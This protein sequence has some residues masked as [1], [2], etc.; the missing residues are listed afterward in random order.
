MIRVLH[1]LP[2]EKYVD[3]VIDLW[4]KTVALCDY[5]CL[6]KIDKSKAYIFSDRIQPISHE[7]LCIKL[8]SNEYDVIVFSSLPVH[9]YQYVLSIPKGKVVIWQSVGYDIYADNYPY[10]A[11]VSLPVYKQI[12]KALIESYQKKSIWMKVRHIIAQT[13]KI[14]ATIKKNKERRSREQ[15]AQE[16]QNE[17]LSRIDYISTVLDSE[18][19]LLRTNP[20]IKAK[21]FRFKYTRPFH[22]SYNDYLIDFHLS[23]YILIGNS[24]DETNNH[25][26][27]LAIVERRNITTPLYVPLA[28]GG[29][30]T[31]LERVKDRLIS[32]PDNI[33]QMTFIER[34][35]YLEILH[36]CR[37]AV[38]GHIR[39]Q[40][41]GNISV[42]LMQGCNVFLYKDSVTY[43][44]Y[45]ELGLYIYSIEEDLT[46]EN[47]DAPL[48]KEQINHNR[49]FFEH[50]YE[51]TLA[52]LQEDVKEIESLVNER[53]SRND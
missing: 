30:Q 39:Q 43:K 53:K 28:Y 15:H 24:G 16:V 7:Q 25:L 27:V 12:T 33:A 20:N 23:K 9:M 11:V 48:T 41:L 4:D 49:S 36:Q 29:E 1:I 47:I 51:D 8:D 34:T 5:V 37:A 44:Y 42:M 19:E 40:A 26:D 22:V 18:Y 50:E 17:V 10:P 6:D 52:D 21:F 31:Y 13:V 14:V 46:Q 35:K 2:Y 3:C 32:N 38:F 45:K